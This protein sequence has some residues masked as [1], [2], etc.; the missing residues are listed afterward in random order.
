MMLFPAVQIVY[1]L[2]L[3]TWFGG[4]LFIAVAAPVIFR[5]VRENNPILPGVLSV[6]LDNQHGTLLAGSIVA[7]LLQILVRVQ[8]LR[9]AGGG[10]FL[11]LLGQVVPGGPAYQ[12]TVDGDHFAQCPIRRGWRASLLQLEVGDAARLG[13]IAK[14]TS[15][16]RTSRK[17]LTR[18][19]SS[20]T[21]ITKTAC[22]C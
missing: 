16:M 10:V 1:W 21:G 7:N 19:A 5:T 11:G 12:D 15:T 2:S 8:G 13:G 17:L 4:V 20:S 6:N 22:C 18:L 14:S 9:T 3:S